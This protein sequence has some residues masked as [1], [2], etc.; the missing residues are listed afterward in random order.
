MRLS[1][2]CWFRSFRT[3][4][5]FRVAVLA[6]VL[7]FAGVQVAKAVAP[8]VLVGSAITATTTGGATIS[9]GATALVTLLGSAVA[10]LAFKDSSGN[11]VRVPIGGASASSVPPPAADSTTSQVTVYLAT[12]QSCSAQ[13]ASAAAACGGL[14]AACNAGQTGCCSAYASTFFPVGGGSVTGGTGCAMTR[15]DGGS[16]TGTIIGPGSMC[17]VGY[18][19]SGGVCTLSNARAVTSDKKTDIARSG[20]TYSREANDVDNGIS[21]TIQGT[22]SG[23]TININAVDAE[24]RPVHYT[25]TA[26]ANG[27]TK[28]EASHQQVTSAG[29]TVVK[30]ST[31]TT[32]SAGNVTAVQQ[33]TLYGKIT[34]GANDAATVD[35]SGGR[36]QPDIVFPCTLR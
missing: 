24:N 2:N 25:I 30:T 15:A 35:T 18:T 26:Q 4:V 21:G 23:S 31:M 5:K 1:S 27:A 3:P 6:L 13:G 36:A 14:A 16:L 10:Y 29:D 11:A 22:V 7:L 8:L 19:L 33:D 28:V 32:D 34:P 12:I 20:T 17:P 9:A